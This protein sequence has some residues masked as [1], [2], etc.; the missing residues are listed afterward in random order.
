MEPTYLMG[1]LALSTL[2]FVILFALRSKKRVE[3]QMEDDDHKPST[4][5]KDG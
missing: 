5:A 2:G 1:F 3:D 4:L